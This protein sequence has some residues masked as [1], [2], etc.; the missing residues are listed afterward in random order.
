MT[1]VQP[2]TMAAP[3]LTITAAAGKF[4]GVMQATTPTGCL[5]V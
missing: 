5:I 1:T 3:A 4:H 2:V